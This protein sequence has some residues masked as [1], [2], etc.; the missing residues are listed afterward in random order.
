[1]SHKVLF[2]AAL[3]VLAF[4][5]LLTGCRR[6]T[7]IIEPPPPE[8]PAPMDP[9]DDPD[10]AP[11]FAPG[12][13]TLKYSYPVGVRIFPR[14]L[15]EATGGDGAL[16]YTLG[17]GNEMLPPG[18]A[19]VDA[20]RALV[21]TP[22]EKGEYELTYRA[23]DADDN[24]DPSDSAVLKVVIS[25]EPA[26]PVSALL[27]AVNVG[28]TEGVLVTGPP[29]E[30]NGGPTVEPGGNRALVSGGAH[31]RRCRGRC[32]TRQVAAVGR[33]AELLRDR[34]GRRHGAV[35]VRRARHAR[36]RGVL[37]TVSFG[38]GSRRRRDGRGGGVP[39]T[40]RGAGNRHR[41]PGDCRLLGH[42]RR[43][44]PARGGRE[45]RRDLL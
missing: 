1:M 39:P 32:R 38:H 33:H 34:P 9:P 24:L 7:P 19:Y 30:A 44:R 17:E 21:G 27:A 41:R 10:T 12:L 23:V 35:S 31:L 36:H 40:R 5:V 37:A 2:H 16:T 42:R 14:P 18:M 3:I 25:V 28:E 45:R 13:E 43:P 4:A 22:Q 26:I 15:P 11:R 8:P 29:P 20:A 6:S